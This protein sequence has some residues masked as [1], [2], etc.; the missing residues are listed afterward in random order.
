M[1]R[2]SISGLL[3]K[4][5]SKVANAKKEPA[6]SVVEDNLIDALDALIEAVKTLLREAQ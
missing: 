2:T 3:W 6:H 1:I 5:E 4:A